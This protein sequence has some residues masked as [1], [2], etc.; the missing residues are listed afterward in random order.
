MNIDDWSLFYK[1]VIPSM[2][3]ETT[4]MVYEPKINQDRTIFC[5]D[6]LYPSQYQLIQTKKFPELYTEK[7]VIEMFE[8]EKKYLS[9]LKEFEWLPE[10][11]DIDESKRRIFFK[12]YDR[13]CNDLLYSKKNDEYKTKI[14]LDGFSKILKDQLANNIYKVSS[15]PHCYYLDADLNMKT[16]DFYACA[17]DEDRYI[18]FDRVK[19]LL[20]DSHK[21]FLDCLVNDNAIDL[22]KMYENNLTKYSFWPNDITRKVYEEFY[23]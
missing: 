16:F 10:I 14:C 12:W 13:S 11:I 23:R 18:D 4:Q 19:A 22:K 9:L 7:F 1:I 20:G 17:T 8:R 6:F 15:Y 2:A 3:L 21:R 5:M